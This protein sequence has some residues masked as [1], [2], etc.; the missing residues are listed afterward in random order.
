MPNTTAIVDSNFY[1]D[2][3]LLA[4]RYDVARG[5]PQQFKVFVPLSG[6]PDSVT[7][8]S[9]GTA[10]PSGGHALLHLQAIT[11]AATL[12]LYMDGHRLMRLEG[13]S[14]LVER[15]N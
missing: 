2:W 9:M 3:Q 13:A 10:T 15:A 4:D 6:D 5:G 11:D 12:D 14:L 1:V 7:M 8:T